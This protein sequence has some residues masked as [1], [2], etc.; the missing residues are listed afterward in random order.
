MFDEVKKSLGSVL[1]SIGNKE[2]KDFTLVVNK[3]EFPVLSGRVSRSIDNC[4]DGCSAIIEL[5]DKVKKTIVPF[6]YEE[7]QVYL[8]GELVITG[9]LYSIEPQ[10]TESEK[11]LTVGIFSP[12][13]DIVD[14]VRYPPYEFKEISL[15]QL[16]EELIG[17]LGLVINF[18]ESLGAQFLDRVCID[19]QQTIF[20]F[21]NDLAAQ[22]GILI[23]SN[24]KGEVV[25]TRANTT[26]KP[27]ETIKDVVNI[28]AK[29]NGRELFAI[30]RVIS[31]TPIRVKKTKKVKK[32]IR[33]K[34]G[35]PYKTIQV[36]KYAEA[37]D[38]AIVPVSRQTSYRADNVNMDEVAKT[39][40]WQR[41][42]RW[43]EALTIRIPRIG[44][45]PQGSKNLYRENT[46]ITLKNKDIWLEKGFNFLIKEVEYTLDKNGAMCVLGL[47]PPQAYTGEE[48][49][50]VFGS[51]S[52]N[53]LNSLKVD[54][55]L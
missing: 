15:Q 22:Y 38:D 54:Q 48:I 39:A 6:G 2:D 18:D 11:L 35:D 53:L 27:V 44:W 47:T 52:S 24:E 13:C 30:Y 41:S 23:T 10:I 37:Y 3:V 49:P 8:G 29:Y 43:A 4:A 36:T 33:Q 50:Y 9:K 46:I 14:G 17:D 21:L 20:N 26:G 19:P 45:H 1:S 31:T 25:F 28:S 42:K 34:P 7:A 12:S 51:N 16:A 32:R 40:E 5:N 55:W